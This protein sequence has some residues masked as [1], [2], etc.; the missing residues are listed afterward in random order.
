[1]KSDSPRVAERASEP[2][3]GKARSNDRRDLMKADDKMLDTLQM[4]A[5]TG[6]QRVRAQNAI[7]AAAAVLSMLL[8]VAQCMGL[9]R[10]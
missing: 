8:G 7:R 6:A 2:E 9:A 5:M 10:K 4:I 3:A 1:M